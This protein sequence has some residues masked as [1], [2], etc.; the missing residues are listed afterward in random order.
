MTTIYHLSQVM[1]GQSLGAG[2]L[3]LQSAREELTALVSLC[4]SSD[5]E[6]TAAFLHW[7][8][9]LLFAFAHLASVGNMEM[10]TDLK[11]PSLLAS[12]RLSR[13]ILQRGCCISFRR[14]HTLEN[15][16]E[17]PAPEKDS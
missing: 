9:I 3:Y 10:L 13:L 1:S 5:N 6:N 12:N 11:H 17:L 16:N 7:S 2:E 15:S 14:L 8:A 4:L